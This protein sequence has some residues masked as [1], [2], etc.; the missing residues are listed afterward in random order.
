MRIYEQMDNASDV[1][2]KLFGWCVAPSENGCQPKT[3]ADI[4]NP[5][6][7]ESEWIL[8]RLCSYGFYTYASMKIDIIIHLRSGFLKTF[9]VDVSAYEAIHLFSGATTMA[10]KTVSRKIT[11]ITFQHLSLSTHD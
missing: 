2:D 1:T 3:V 8:P 10:A 11:C 5:A 7:G 6:L 4:Y 9:I